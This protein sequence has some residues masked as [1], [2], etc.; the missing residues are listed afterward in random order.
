MEIKSRVPGLDLIAQSVET[1]LWSEDLLNKILILISS[2]HFMSRLSISTDVLIIASSFLLVS[3]I[4]LQKS[5]LWCFSYPNI[6]VLRPFTKIVY[7]VI[8]VVFCRQQQKNDTDALVQEQEMI[9]LWS[10][11]RQNEHLNVNLSASLFILPHIN[12]RPSHKWRI[13][14]LP[15]P[16]GSHLVTLSFA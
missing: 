9:P 8:L 10:C 4:V 6:T 14:Y 2:E 1:M 3:V 7:A 15:V 5:C 16:A 11:G 12:P 13:C